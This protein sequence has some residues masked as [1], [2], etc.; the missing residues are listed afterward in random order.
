MSSEGESETK[1]PSLLRLILDGDLEGVK[2]SLAA[3]ADVDQSKNGLTPVLV[4]VFTD[5]EERVL[6]YLRN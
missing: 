1:N 3:G 5:D 4:T 2:S 6:S